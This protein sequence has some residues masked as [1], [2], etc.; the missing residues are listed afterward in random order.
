MSDA[1][2]ELVRR[3]IVE[4][5]SEGKLDVADEIIAPGFVRHDLAGQS[6]TLGPEGT[7]RFIGAQRKV[8]ADLAM[9]IDGAFACGDMVV[10]RYT[11]T[12]RHAAELMG[13]APT[14]KEVSWR[15]I[16]LYRIEDG[17]LAETWQLADMLGVMRQ[18][19]ALA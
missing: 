15:G 5:A 11:A 10:A 19:G 8:F 9:A 12:G 7:K 1:N 13:V 3:A 14:G 18:L 6:M 16:N 17:K 2:I 4:I